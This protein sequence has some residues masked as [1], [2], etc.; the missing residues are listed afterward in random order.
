MEG[1][2]EVVYLG[3]TDGDCGVLYS[4]NDLSTFQRD[5]LKLTAALPPIFNIRWPASAA[6]G[7]VHATMPFV[8][9]TTLRLLGNWVNGGLAIG[10]MESEVN[11]ILERAR[12]EKRR[13]VLEVRGKNERLGGRLVRNNLMQVMETEQ[14]QTRQCAADESGCALLAIR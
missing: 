3:L 2:G 14:S 9:W 7:C 10:Y 11:C 8:L 4:V 13:K 6:N 12:E 1:G 5:G